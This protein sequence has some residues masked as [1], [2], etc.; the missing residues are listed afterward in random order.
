MRR[1]RPLIAFLGIRTSASR[2]Q[3]AT[4][5]LEFFHDTE[6]STRHRSANWGSALNT[7]ASSTFCGAVDEFFIVQARVF[8][9]LFAYPILDCVDHWRWSA[10]VEI[11]RLS[12]EGGRVEMFGYKA[13]LAGPIVRGV[14]DHRV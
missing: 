2:L 5:G 11:K 4:K 1:A 6:L 7:Y 10:Y 13:S 14:T 3:A 8:N 12:C 9:T